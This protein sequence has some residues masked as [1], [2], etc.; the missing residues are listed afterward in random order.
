M[1]DKR[2][3]NIFLDSDNDLEI[4]IIETPY[5]TMLFQ[6]KYRQFRNETNADIK[7]LIRLSD[8]PLWAKTK[9]TSTLPNYF[10]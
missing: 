3:E 5:G 4:N 7:E 1:I 6:L 10:N 9:I 2:L 8:I